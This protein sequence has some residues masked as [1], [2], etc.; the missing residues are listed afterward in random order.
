MFILSF[1][2]YD[3]VIM[4]LTR[5]AVFLILYS[6]KGSFY[7]RQILFGSKDT[8]EMEV[9]RIN[10]ASKDF[11]FCFQYAAL[12]DSMNVEEGVWLPFLVHANSTKEEMAGK[13]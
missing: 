6:K 2:V 9:A 13:W 11:W 12:F 7:P 5:K 8:V 4:L 10:E 3:M 1:V